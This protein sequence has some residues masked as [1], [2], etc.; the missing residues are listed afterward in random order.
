[1]SAENT[2]TEFVSDTA[3]EEACRKKIPGALRFYKHCGWN[4]ADYVVIWY[5]VYYLFFVC[6]DVKRNDHHRKTIS[7]KGAPSR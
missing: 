6:G 4:F 1:M 2:A 5:I 3:L 7:L